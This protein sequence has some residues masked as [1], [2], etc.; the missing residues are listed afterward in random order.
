MRFE[1]WPPWVVSMK[2]GN[3]L[4]RPVLFQR[5]EKELQVAS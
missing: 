5:R 4:M 1:R 2:Y 3:D